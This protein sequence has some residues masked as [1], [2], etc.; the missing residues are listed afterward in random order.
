MLPPPGAVPR[1]VASCAVSR[2]VDIH[3][4]GAAG[5]EYGVDEEGSRR[6]AAHHRAAGSQM[7]VA[8]LVSAAPDVLERQVVTLA[9]LVEDGTLS[10]IHLEGP[11][12]GRRAGAHRPADVVPIDLIRNTEK[13]A[14]WMQ[15][16]Q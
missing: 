9:P 15:G 7:L 16:L 8:S 4:H 13:L 1:S 2:L 14:R 10:G 11:F 3:H 5:A 6:A 12:L